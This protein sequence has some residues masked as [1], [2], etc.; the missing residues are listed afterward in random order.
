MTGKW[1]DTWGLLSNRIM[2]LLLTLSWVSLDL[3]VNFSSF[4]GKFCVCSHATSSVRDIGHSRGRGHV[5]YALRSGR[6]CRIKYD[7][8]PGQ[9]W[10]DNY[11]RIK[12]SY[13][14]EVREHIF[15][16]ICVK[17]IYT[18]KFVML[19]WIKF[20]YLFITIPIGLCIGYCSYPICC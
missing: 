9:I 5:Y 15:F 20:E 14:H 7:L 1:W 11:L 3:T 2:R 12:C 13:R 10:G 17:F 4:N 18:I 8:L 19:K 16:F 6:E